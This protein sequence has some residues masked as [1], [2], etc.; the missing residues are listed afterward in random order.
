[1]VYCFDLQE[2]KIAELR[3]RKS[4]TIAMARVTTNYFTKACH[5]DKS[6][7]TFKTSGIFLSL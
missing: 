4:H 6:W 3:C 7:R 2:M 5:S 1:V